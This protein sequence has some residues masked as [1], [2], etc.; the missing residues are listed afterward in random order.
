MC[1]NL[2]RKGYNLM[3]TNLLYLDFPS[4]LSFFK[5]VVFSFFFGDIL[6]IIMINLALR[7]LLLTSFFLS[8]SLRYGLAVRN[9]VLH[10]RFCSALIHTYIFSLFSFSQSLSLSLSLS[11]SFLFRY[12]IYGFVS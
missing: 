11:L 12:V 7:G 1:I 8:L 6:L 4:T 2:Y 10:R 3:S 9:I 5:Y